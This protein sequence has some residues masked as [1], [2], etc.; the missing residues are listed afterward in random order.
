SELY[1]AMG[2]QIY[3][4][5]IS[6]YGWAEWKK[7]EKEIETTQQLSIFYRNPSWCV[8]TASTIVFFTV[9]LLLL[10][11]LKNLTGDPMP[12]SDAAATSLSVV[13]TYWLSKSYRAQWLIWIVVN[14]ITVALCLSQELYPTSI[15]YLIYTVSALYGYFHWGKKGILL[16]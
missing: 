12:V 14:V 4:L 5:A 16:S 13:A 1:A 6:I 7:S 2:F 8:I 9:F 11:V 15:L 10:T 3:Y